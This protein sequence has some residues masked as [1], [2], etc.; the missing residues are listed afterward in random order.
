MRDQEDKE[1]KQI[2]CVRLA[3]DWPK[4]PQELS[5]LY[6]TLHVTSL[7]RCLPKVRICDPIYLKPLQVRTRVQQGS[8]NISV[9]Q[10]TKAH[11]DYAF[12]GSHGTA[13]RDETMQYERVSLGRRSRLYCAYA[14]FAVT[15]YWD[16]TD[17]EIEKQ[18]ARNVTAAA[19]VHH[20]R[21]DKRR[22]FIQRLTAAH[23]KSLEFNNSSGLPFSTSKPLQPATP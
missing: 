5:Q 10:R 7:P 21:T 23:N 15:N 6:V 20:S 2:D 13:E 8:N 18:Q 19:N 12:Y 4:S 3:E 17:A 14:V 16:K 1:Q 11:L 22:S 9:F